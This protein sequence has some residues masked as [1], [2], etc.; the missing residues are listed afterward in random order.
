MFK[1]MATAVSFLLIC[2]D[3]EDADSDGNAVNP[4]DTSTFLLAVSSLPTISGGKRAASP[5][6]RNFENF[7]RHTATYYEWLR[8]NSTR[9][10]SLLGA[11]CL[12]PTLA[13]GKDVMSVTRLMQ[14]YKPSGDEGGRR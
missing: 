6:D 13:S 11:V 12:L 7:S 2:T 14:F 9:I 1:A 5:V 10:L 8:R 4:M 3:R